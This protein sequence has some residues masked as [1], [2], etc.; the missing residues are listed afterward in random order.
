[1]LAAMNDVARKPSETEGE[2]AREIENR[3]EK[4]EQAAEKEESAAEI[5]EV[6]HRRIIEENLRAE[7]SRDAARISL[8]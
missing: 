6:A 5:A 1:M 7:A 2:F 8:R 3:T 4:R